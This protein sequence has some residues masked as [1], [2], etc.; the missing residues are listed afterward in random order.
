[1]QGID[2]NYV[3]SSFTVFRQL[4]LHFPYVSIRPNA[5]AVAMAAERPLT[6]IAVCL[7]S[8]AARPDIQSRLAQAFRLALSAKVIIQGE[9]SFDLLIGLLIFLAWH[10]NYMTKQQIYQN[11]CLLAGMATDLGLYQDR[12][13][14]EL[15]STAAVER[16]RT[17]LGCYYLCC[18]L[19]IMGFN[20]PNPMRWTDNLRKCAENVAYSG[21]LPSDRSLVAMTELARAID[22]LDEALRSMDSWRPLIT[23]QYVDMQ[24]KAA[25]HRLKALKREHPALSSALLYEAAT[26]HFHHRL[27][28]ASDN[29]DT[30]TLIQCACAVKEY[31]DGILARPPITLHQVAIVDWTNCLETLILMTRIAKP[32]PPTAGW[33][34]GALSSMLQPEALLDAITN[35]MASAP[36][37]DSL[38]PRHEGQLHGLKAVCEGIKKRILR[39]ENTPREDNANMAGRFRPVNEPYKS[40]LPLPA[41]DKSSQDPGIFDSS[42]IFDNGVLDDGFWSKILGSQP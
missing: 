40:E 34:S 31:L 15:H 6:S 38:A 11:L 2:Y 22:D 24:T 10:H 27:L 36:P 18:C 14:S 23:A 9:R 20:K 41:S 30:S 39:G 13:K 35:H 21:A 32:L 26:I 19:S 42:S 12:S 37:G 7:V 16:D 33:E 3:Q 1:L 25:S 29:S 5:D 8:S 28:R 4:T 17:W